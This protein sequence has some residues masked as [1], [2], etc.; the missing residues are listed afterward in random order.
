MFS[1][2]SKEEL[3]DSTQAIVIGLY[4][5]NRHQ[6]TVYQE[7]NSALG[8]VL[9]DYV[10][11]GDLSNDYKSVTKVYTLG[12][13]EPKRIYV[14][15]LG[16]KKDLTRSS[17]I[18][19]LGY[20]AKELKKDRIT[21]FSFVLDSFVSDQ[22][23]AEEVS[24]LLAEATLT[25]TYDFPNYKTNNQKPPFSFESVSVIT[26]HP[27]QKSLEEGHA[28]ADGINTARYLV[29]LP[30]NLLTA[31]DLAHYAEHLAHDLNLEIEILDKE[32]LERLGMGALLA[33]NQGSVEPPKMIVLKYQGKE[34][35]E[36][37]VG[38]VGKGIT[39]DTGG[40]S[41]KSKDGIV[42]MKTDMGG[43]A[44]VLGAM[45]IIGRLKPKANV[46]AVIPS[47]DNMVSGSAFKPDDVI[48]SFSGKTIEV[49]NTDAEG[50]LALADA[51]TYAKHHGA[52]RL[53]DVATL[54]GGVIVALGDWVT[55]AMTNDQEYYQSFEKVTEWTDEP[56]WQLPYLPVYQEKVRGSELADLNNSPGRKAHPIMA[57][58]F[59]AEFAE[60]TPWIHLDI[61]GTATSDKEY[62]LGPKGPTGV[63]VKSLAAY[64]LKGQK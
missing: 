55:G 44:S 51:I 62:D 26:D 18:K 25:A 43:A 35:W 64:V 40:Y 4:H 45:E 29:Q 11:H 34:K 38:L 56:I 15:G 22:F 50:R 60:N 16:K 54:T 17:Y 39:F 2:K 59:I 47:T 24:A 46:V 41:L 14:L 23:S 6:Q 8:E 10:K 9:D 5:E 1:I 7:I 33:V 58:A 20:L 19:A 49:L 37:V 30:S 57:G 63:M 12:R 31:T 3:F 53:I 28:Y 36:D 13:I 21:Q 42:G 52:S 48:T 27:V 61:A 32:D